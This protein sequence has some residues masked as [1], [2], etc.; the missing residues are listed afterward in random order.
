MLSTTGRVS[1]SSVTFYGVALYTAFAAHLLLVVVLASKKAWQKF[2]LFT[3]YCVLTLA[4]S[5][6]CFAVRNDPRPFFFAYWIN[7][8]LGVFLGLAVVYEIFRRLLQDHPTLRKMAFWI[9]GVTFALLIALG[10]CVMFS[11]LSPGIQGLVQGVF[12]IELAARVVEIGLFM[13]LFLFASVFGLHWKRVE[14]GIAVG[15]GLFVAVEITNLTMGT[16]LG[17]I[18]AETFRIVRAISFNLSLLIWLGY[19]LIPER[20]AVRTQL[21][22]RAQLE[23]WNQAMLELI[24]Q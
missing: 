21:P 3:I 17:P 23:Q 14:F 5:L 4:G 13:F 7:E 6:T 16:H 22:Q 24:K 19:I 9:F 2:P 20:I 11:K 1:V 8:C 12:V 10:L 15:L 18:V